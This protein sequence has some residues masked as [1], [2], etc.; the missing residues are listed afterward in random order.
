MQELAKELK[1]GDI[2]ATPY[3]KSQQVNACAYCQYQSVCNFED[4]KHGD[5][6][7]YLPKLDADTV[8][9]MMEQKVEGGAE[10]GRI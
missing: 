2:S 3:Y 5:K 10:D 6:L 8:W 9:D 4:G 1:D 7:R